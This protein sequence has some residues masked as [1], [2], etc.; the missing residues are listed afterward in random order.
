MTLFILESVAFRA[1]DRLL[2]S[3]RT[4]VTHEP[5]TER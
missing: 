2:D 3:T 5:E 1:V 4:P